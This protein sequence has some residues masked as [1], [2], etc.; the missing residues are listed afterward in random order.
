VNSQER[1]LA[2]LDFCPHDR[3]PTYE[4][5]WEEFVDA[6]RQAKG[7]PLDADI[8]DYYRTDLDITIPDETP[9]PSQAGLLESGPGYE[10]H[11]TGWGMVQRVEAEGKFYEEVDVAIKTH[12][13]LD[14]VEFESPLLESRFESVAQVRERSAKQC[15]FVKTGG[16]YL[17]TSNLRGS[18]QWLLDLAEDPGFA[19]ELAMRVT[20]HITAVGLEALRRYNLYH[21][22]IWFFDDMA[23]NISPMFSPRTFKR[24][25]L[26]CYQWM[27]EQYR[28]AGVQHIQ[29]HCDG[30]IEAIL[31][32]LIDAGIQAIH[33]VEPKAGM[34]IVALRKRYGRRLAFLGGLDN[35]HIMATAS[36][37]ELREHVL[38]VLSVATDGKT[39][40]LVVGGHSIGPDVSVE[41]YDFV[42][43]LIVEHGQF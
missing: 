24:V 21:T 38:R 8:Y 7:L 42:H 37:P 4:S 22:G 9:F 13:D 10:L 25:F 29:L 43:Q 2:A 34:D 17:R 28:A 40:G 23:S 27:C 11:R 32:P 30:N 35:A 39:G 3:I 14:R 26:P 31:E 41:R 16:P 12:V 5:F 36:L 1:V 18:S 19:Y 20:Q 15:I 6:W 33:P